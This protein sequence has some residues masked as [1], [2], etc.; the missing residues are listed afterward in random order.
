VNNLPFVRSDYT[1][2]PFRNTSLQRKPKRTDYSATQCD[3]SPEINVARNCE[4]VEVD[5]AGYLFESLVEL[6]DLSEQSSLR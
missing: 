2:D 5:D 1:G 4:V 6:G 3:V